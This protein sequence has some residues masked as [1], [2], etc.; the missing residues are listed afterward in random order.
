MIKL[1][2]LIGIP[3]RIKS[4]AVIAVVALK[5]GLQGDKEE[6]LQYC[7]ENMPDYRVPK[8]V[9]IRDEIPRDPAGKLLRRVLRQDAQNT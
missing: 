7:K 2:I 9:L 3:D 8:T 6:F 1:L 5:E 4:Q